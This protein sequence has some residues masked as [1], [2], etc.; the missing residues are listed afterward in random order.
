[1]AVSPFDGSGDSYLPA[2]LPTFSGDFLMDDRPLIQNNSYIKTLQSP[3]SYL[4]QEDGITD[5]YDS[6]RHHTGYYRP[7]I[8]LTYYAGG[9]AEN[10]LGQKDYED[11]E[12]FFQ[13]AIQKYPLNAKN[14][15]N[16]S[17][18]LI[19]TGRPGAALIY[20]KKAEDLGMS[21]YRR[22]QWFN[23]MGAA[24][25]HLKKYGEALK[26]FTNAVTYYPDNADYHSNL[27]GAYA[28]VGNYED[29][30][31]VLERGLET[32]PDSV[33]L[34]KNLALI[35]IRMKKYKDAMS[36]LEGI[37]KKEWERHGAQKI[38]EEAQAGFS[39]GD[40]SD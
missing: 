3:F 10:L 33:V 39:T 31:S 15:L 18:L 16:Y 37:P 1:L 21:R 5:E 20:L 12:R 4:A 27:G 35:N 7:F 38:F 28:A 30:I 36:V 13:V 24:H 6:D 14:Y 11:A 25:F 26:Y 9:L 29:G 8:N 23:N 34:R 22:G 2:D 32:A 17:A 40:V 19:D